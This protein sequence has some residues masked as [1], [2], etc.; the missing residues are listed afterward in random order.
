M[1]S[2]DLLVSEIAALEPDFNVSLGYPLRRSALCHLLGCVF[3]AQR[4][5]RDGAYHAR[6]YLRVL[7]HPLVKNLA[8]T[9]DGAR[10]RILV[11]KV[12]EA[13][14][15]EGGS[16]LAGSLF[17]RLADLEADASIPRLAAA[18]LGEMGIGEEP[19]ALAAALAA[20]H[21]AALRPWERIESFAGFAAALESFVDVLVRRSPL[22][23]YPLNLTFAG[24][25]LSM[26][27]G[28]AESEAGGE[29]F[30]REEIFRLFAR[31]LER[32]TIGFSGSPLR[33]LQILGL[34]ETR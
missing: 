8:E 31:M 7:S 18:S 27:A 30:E 32:E 10:T 5:M 17:V 21:A 11:H 28:L 24:R 25:L 23:R 26:A 12:E 33:G 2:S 14:R 15:G 20:I 19:A 1:C 4:G 29:R 22:E 16:P 9:G 3:D 13:L 34:M 6:A